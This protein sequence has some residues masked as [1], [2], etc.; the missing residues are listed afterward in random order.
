M[1]SLAALKDVRSVVYNLIPEFGGDTA[2]G[3][4]RKMGVIAQE[5]ETVLPNLVDRTNPEHLSVDYTQL[6]AYIPLLYKKILE[7]EEK[8]TKLES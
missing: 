8:I 5:L 4:Q 2:F 1:N 6:T 3:S 7:L